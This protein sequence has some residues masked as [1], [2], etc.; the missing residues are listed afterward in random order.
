R[1]GRWTSAEVML[2]RPLGYG[3]Y[4]FHVRDTSELDPAA[5]LQTWSWDELRSDQNYAELNIDVSRW[6]DPRSKNAQFAVQPA[7]VAANVFRF[8]APSGRLTHSF[9]WE[10]GKAS[11]RTVSG[12]GTRL[13]GALVAERQFTAGVPAPGTATI[14]IALLYA[15]ESP[16]PPARDVE[17]AV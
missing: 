11:F 5:A 13:P 15:R 14:H 1:D 8:S 12:S 4:E 7:Y 3:T 10:P 9:R 6:G 2:T 17:V 16:I